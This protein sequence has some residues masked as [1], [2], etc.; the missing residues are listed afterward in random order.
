MRCCDTCTQPNKQQSVCG[1]LTYTY[2]Q[3]QAHAC[4][5]HKPPMKAESMISSTLRSVATLATD[6]ARPPLD[7]CFFSFALMRLRHFALPSLGGRLRDCTGRFCSSCGRASTSGRFLLLSLSA[8]S[9][10][11]E[12]SCIE[13]SEALV[14]CELAPG[15]LIWRETVVMHVRVTETLS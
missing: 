15:M 1:F 11:S 8:P 12:A 14:R 6:G 7:H 4:T 3:R 2:K 9:A 5:S 13:T 10:D